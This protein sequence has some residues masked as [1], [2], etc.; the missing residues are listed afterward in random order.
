MPPAATP[1]EAPEPL[2]GAGA[3]P[4]AGRGS[5]GPRPGPGPAA[6]EPAEPRGAA[7]S[8]QGG[9][10][11]PQPAPFRR[12]GIV[13]CGLIGGSL[14]LAVRQAP[15][16]E[17]VVVTDR[18]PGV[19]EQARDLGGGIAVV[20]SLPETVA[21]A[22]LVVLAVPV[23]DI[24]S[25]ARDIAEYLEAGAV[26]T[27]VGS[28]KAKAV[29]EIESFL[30]FSASFIGGH[31]MAGS[32]ESGL[33]A[34]DSR[35][36]QGVTYLL[37]PTEGARPEA[38]DRLA[39]LLRSLGARVLAIDPE[40]HDR[41]VAVVSHLPQVL[42]SVLMVQAGREAESRAG[43]LAVAAGGFRDVTRVASSDPGLWL[44]ILRENRRAVLAALERFTELVGEFGQA[45]R[46]G[47]WGRVHELLTV[48]RQ[49]RAALP[50]KPGEGLLV[51]VVVP[52][53]DRPGAL[54]Q[55]TTA[56]GEAGI[57]IEDLSLRHAS[58]GARG[59]LVIAVAG[60]EAAARAREVLAAGGYTAHLEVL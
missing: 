32:E 18:D 54:A 2:R 33:E 59:A 13:G 40:V 48:A 7:P 27:D 14:A 20:D 55:V 4:P 43:V 49:G 24:S 52:V 1:G 50:G 11:R 9:P 28:V 36:F 41:V 29:A 8:R 60:Q 6:G 46:G 15:G 23:E 34:A 58:E 17:E 19:L 45:M 22:D 25:V 30:P 21:G 10:T 39:G 53:P 51:D 3:P 44:G 26:L 56:L 47:E 5:A 12:I 57:N 38:F 31:P 37:T 42:A 35:L 16:V